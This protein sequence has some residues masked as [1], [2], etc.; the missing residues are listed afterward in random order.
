VYKKKQKKFRREGKR[1]V[2]RM[3]EGGRGRG[4]ENV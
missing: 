4:E 1:V 2:R 3:G